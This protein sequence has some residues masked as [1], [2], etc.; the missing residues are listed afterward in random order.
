MRDTAS[1]RLGGSFC[2]GT[3]SLPFELRID[4]ASDTLDVPSNFCTVADALKREPIF[5]ENC[6]DA[7]F[8]CLFACVP[9][10]A[11]SNYQ[12]LGSIN[13]GLL[14]NT[15][16]KNQSVRNY[17]PSLE[18]LRFYLIDTVYDGNVP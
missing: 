13:N 15:F 8:Y 16:V 1:V 14:Y 7:R 5:F 3:T 17:K 18:F 11:Y 2:F 9:V 12:G 4:E 6:I 10:Q